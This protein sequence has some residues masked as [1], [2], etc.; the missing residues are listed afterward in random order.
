[1]CTGTAISWKCHSIDVG[2][3][4]FMKCGVADMT[5]ECVHN[6]NNVP[7]SLSDLSILAKFNAEF[8]RVNSGYREGDKTQFSLDISESFFRV[9]KVKLVRQ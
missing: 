1:M 7:P 5:T 4:K 6:N 3:T 8:G 9:E 2:F